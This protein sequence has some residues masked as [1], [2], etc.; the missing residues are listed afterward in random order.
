[1][2]G[3]ATVKEHREEDITLLCVTHHREVTNGLLARETVE[4]A[5]Q[6]PYNLRNGTSK[7]YFLNYAGGSLVT[8]LGGNLFHTQMPIIIDDQPIIGY[9]SDG[10]NLL[11]YVN[12]FDEN[13]DLILAIHENELVYSI[14][15]WDI[16]LEGNQ[17][18]LRAAKEKFMIRMRFLVP[19]KLLIDRGTIHYRDRSI[20]I[21]DRE[22]HVDGNNIRM[23]GCEFYC[24][25]GVIIGEHTQTAHVRFVSPKR[26]VSQRNK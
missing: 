1:M 8:E 20:T 19:N 5:N 4:A 21:K 25:V 9:E 12:L 18:T 26:L 2:K 23:I 7:P 10:E 13:G 24:A 22:M 17:L 6:A 14:D 16:E 3:W 15:P 11:L